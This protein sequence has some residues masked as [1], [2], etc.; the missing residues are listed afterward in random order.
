MASNNDAFS[1]ETL[2]NQISIRALQQ[3]LNQEMGLDIPILNDL[4][5][6]CMQR[7]IKKYLQELVEYQ[8]WQTELHR[9]NCELFIL[10]Q[11]EIAHLQSALHQRNQ[12]IAS[13]QQQCAWFIRWIQ[14]LQQQ[15]T[16]LI[17]WIH[18]LR[19]SF[20]LYNDAPPTVPSDWSDT[21]DIH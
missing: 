1:D 10:N 2:D 15:C 12:E 8:S 11:Q 14:D 17:Q 7:D 18:A 5:Y 4:G 13:L 6:A 16:S 3:Q 21:D 20:G 19:A 9:L